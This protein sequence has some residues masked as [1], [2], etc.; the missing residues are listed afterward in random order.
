MTQ[1]I[2]LSEAR[3]QLSALLREIDSDPERVYRI[4]VHNRVVAELRSAKPETP[5]LESGAALLAAVAEMERLERGK[6]PRKLRAI[7][8]NFKEYL[9]GWPRSAPS[10]RS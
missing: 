9:Y 5:R 2:G 7:S 1:E 8:E 3:R 10:R 4:R 6:K